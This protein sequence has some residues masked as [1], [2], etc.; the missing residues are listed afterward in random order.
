MTSCQLKVVLFCTG[1]GADVNSYRP[2]R[3]ESQWWNRRDALCRCVASFLFGPPSTNNS[4]NNDRELIFFYDGD[5]TRIHMKLDHAAAR[6]N[7]IFPSEHNI[8][9][10]WKEAVAKAIQ[11]FP[12]AKSKTNPPIVKRENLLCWV[13]LS[14]ESTVSSNNNSA[15]SS[16]TTTVNMKMIQNWNKRQ[17]LEYLHKQCST[18]FLRENRLNAAPD[19]VL[20][21]SNRT[22]LSKI[23]QQWINKQS[24][25]PPERTTKSQPD[26][27]KIDSK[28]AFG[29]KQLE[30]TFRDIFA[31]FTP[32]NDDNSD[33]EQSTASNSSLIA[34]TLHESSDCE[35]PCFE[36]GLRT[37][38]N[39]DT[40][41]EGPINLCLFLGAV[42]D[43]IPEEYMALERVCQGNHSPPPIPLV[44]VRLG[45]VPE[46][47]SKILS[48]VAFHHAQEKLGA[49]IQKLVISTRQQQQQL[50]GQ[51][52]KRCLDQVDGN[53]NDLLLH[54]QKS[55]N[56]TPLL[57][58]LCLVPLQSDDLALDLDKRNR[59]LWCIVRV[60]VCA[61]WRSRLASN[62]SS[63]NA[64]GTVPLNNQ[65][66]LVFL[67][68]FYLTL[69]QNEWVSTLAEQ[70]QAAPSEY[71]VLKALIDM[72]ERQKKRVGPTEPP[73]SKTNVDWERQSS[74]I[75]DKLKQQSTRN[76]SVSDFFHLLSLEKGASRDLS[77]HFYSAPLRSGT[78]AQDAPAGS[79]NNTFALLCI[80]SDN[81]P[82]DKD[83]AHVHKNFLRALKRDPCWR[84]TRQSLIDVDNNGHCVD[85]EAVSVTT[86]QHFLYQERLWL[87]KL[88]ETPQNIDGATSHAYTGP[89]AT[90]TEAETSGEV[91]KKKSRKETKS[92]KK[93]DTKRKKKK[94]RKT[95]IET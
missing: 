20:R 93:K 83:V 53:G 89:S 13:V 17:L 73:S 45:W 32:L 51:S 11:A 31:T 28:K 21:K 64:S 12:N 25:A 90:K 61:L 33:G 63:T 36:E 85:W 6:N 95:S 9:A 27:R 16:E 22:A 34:A 46:F 14:P 55:T 57:H 23:F 39:H 29:T 40:S 54:S 69:E 67:D 8:I 60:L 78:I 66:T 87:D 24:A 7:R 75:L 56:A 15:L 1:E 71:Q 10:L 4:R 94:R 86:L 35:L 5:H 50:G 76:C 84:V 30:S 49:A 81:P 74:N 38:S 80:V 82:V 92:K 48:I 70:H 88:Q 72:V 43:M 3:D 2:K 65:V 68:G 47:T 79:A 44:K 19:V 26:N 59:T 62:R 77:K 18:E 37:T 52:R 42:R 58:T 91:T 41:N